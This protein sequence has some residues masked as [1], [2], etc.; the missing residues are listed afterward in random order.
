MIVIYMW[1]LT[2][3]KPM[4]ASGLQNVAIVKV[5]DIRQ[6]IVLRKIADQSVLSV[7]KIMNLD[8]VQRKAPLSV[9]IV[10]AW[11]IELHP[12]ITLRPAFPVL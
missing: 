8:H 1:V 9:Q 3:A 10:F 2:D 11:R 6:Q 4:I 12:W 5:L 7:L